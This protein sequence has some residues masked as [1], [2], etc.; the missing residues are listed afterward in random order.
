MKNVKQYRFNGA[1][2]FQAWIH[3]RNIESWRMT[4]PASMG[5]C[6]FRHG[7]YP[8]PARQVSVHDCFNG[9]MPFQA[10]ILRNLSCSRF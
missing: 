8:W 1:M 3:A 7:Y 6:P 4:F 2:P 10:W 5:P 9:A